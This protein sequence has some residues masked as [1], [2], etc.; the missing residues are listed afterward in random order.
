MRKPWRMRLP[1]RQRAGPG[2][3]LAA[4]LVALPFLLSALAGCGEQELPTPPQVEEE[5]AAANIPG[6]SADQSRTVDRYGYPDHFFISIDPEGSERIETWVY[7][8]HGKALDFDNGRLFGEEPAADESEKY[9]PTDLRPQDFDLLMTPGEA[10]ALL[11]DP[12]YTH[13]VQDSLM[14]ENTI[15]IYDGVILLYRGE[16]LMGVDTQVAP[17]GLNAP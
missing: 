16:R 7:F 17:P 13:A 6:L 8:E 5:T 4:A 9:P 11:G 14:P 2:A 1:R 10:T 12:L 15:V 3:V